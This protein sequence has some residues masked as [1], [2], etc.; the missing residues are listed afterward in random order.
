MLKTYL[1]QTKFI[2]NN[3]N[4]KITTLVRHSNPKKRVDINILLNKIKIEEKNRTKK[5]IIF[6]S[7]IISMLS[8]FIYIIA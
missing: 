3:N 4:Q 5:N 2:D 8:A 6:Y 7:S 1:H